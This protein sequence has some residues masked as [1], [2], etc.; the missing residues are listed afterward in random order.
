MGFGDSLKKFASAAINPTMLLGSAAAMGDAIYTGKKNEQLQNR[1]N[2]FNA[3]EAKK[4][5]DW[6]EMMSNT[7]HQRE[8]KDLKSAGLNPLL[9]GTGGASTPGGATASGSAS[10]YEGGS[11]TRGITS[12]IEMNAMKLANAK[13]EKE[14]GLMDAQ[15]AKTETETKVIGKGIP[16]AD[17]KN[18]MWKTIKPI[19]QKMN[20]SVRNI[21]PKNSPKFEKNRNEML[22]RIRMNNLR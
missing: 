20:E 16:E 14:L 11:L 19:F 12:A 18:E 6:Q 8:I 21:S 10:S 15:K 9:S 5:R 22:N 1:A 17:A 7:S 3:A 13:A 2:D 4:N